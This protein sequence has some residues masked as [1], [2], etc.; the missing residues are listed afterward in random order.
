M[1]NLDIFV[2][3]VIQKKLFYDNLLIFDD[4]NILS[5]NDEL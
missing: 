4:I 5:T 1:E 2:K 3:K